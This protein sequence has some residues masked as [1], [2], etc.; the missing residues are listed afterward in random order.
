MTVVTPV[1]RV[2]A[3]AMAL[4][5]L[6]TV[7]AGCAR[8]PEERKPSV[9][10]ETAKQQMIDAVDEVTGRLGGEWKPRTGPDYAERC[11][12]PDGEDGAHWV[13]LTGRADGG[14]PQN[15]AAE[16]AD[17]WEA[18]GMTIERWGKGDRPAIVGRGGGSVESISLYAY[19]GNYTVQALSLCFPGDAD[20]L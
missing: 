4:V 13:Y 20:E 7:L 3:S 11:Q 10:P 17:R 1:G 8:H 9:N 5:A 12:L 15:D 18:Q 6:V 2:A 16:T 19:P 14:D